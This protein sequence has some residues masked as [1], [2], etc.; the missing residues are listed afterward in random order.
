M[1]K[2]PTRRLISQEDSAVIER[3]DI[4]RAKFINQWSRKTSFDAGL[5]Y[6]IMVE[7][8]LPGD[9]LQYSATIYARLSTP[10]F[11]IF[12]NQ[13][14][15]THGFFV[16]WRLVW[17][18][19]QRFMGE[20][21]LGPTQDIESFI[22]PQIVLTEPP[23]ANSLYDHM[24]LPVTN[25]TIATT[26]S[27]NAMFFRAYNLIWNTWFRDQN[28]QDAVPF[29]T[30]NG[31]A[32][33]PLTNYVLLYRAKAHDYFTSAL[34][35]AQKFTPPTIPLGGQAWVKGLGFLDTDRLTNPGP[36]T[37]RE[38]DG[39]TA[40]Y[41]RFR[42][43]GD[44]P[45]SD[46]VNNLM[47]SAI[48]TAGNDGTPQ[49]YADLGESSGITI[50]QLRQSFLLQTLLERDAR[51]GTRYIEI[52]KSQWG[53]TSQDARLQRP[54]YIGGGSSM[55]NITPIAQTA[56]GTESV[57][58][59]LGGAGTATGKHRLSFSSTEYG[60]I[61]WLMSVRTELTYMQGTHRMW[62]R[63]TRFD[64][65]FPALAG[66]GEQA[67][68]RKEIYDTG[69][70]AD[71]DNDIVFGYQE[72][73]HEFRTRTSEAVGEFNV[74][75][76][77]LDAWHLGQSFFPAPTLSPAFIIDNPPME[78]VLAAGEEAVGQQYLADILFNRTAV[79][80]LPAHGTPVSLG[81]I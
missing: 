71:T 32:G 9:N 72:R 7:E 80:L 30:G 62:N 19:W 29:F 78:R 77:G 13:R 47:V 15:D 6:P 2:F 50:N 20:Q 35:W 28:I 42:N 4:P 5:I 74:G 24:G 14:I 39:T 41:A 40:V 33:D 68:L 75:Q 56:P 16:P 36:I 52:I 25:W 66:L 45:G 12:D 22:V 57:V 58:G 26:K 79:R 81:R 3:P 1:I 64:Y 73:Y 65:P 69:E 43:A 63:L 46:E 67:I 10:L 21:D 54:E 11:P 55:M 59:A 76:A 53:V 8:V 27:I 34:P 18:N 61:L 49:I 51:G 44:D 31:E 37:V 23:E 17:S 48:G 38:S 60:C 70:D